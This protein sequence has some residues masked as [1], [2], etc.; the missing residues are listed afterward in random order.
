MFC[1]SDELECILTLVWMLFGFCRSRFAG[2][3]HHA[4][5]FEKFLYLFIFIASV[6]LDDGMHDVVVLDLGIVV[7]FK[8]D[9]VCQFFL[10]RAKLLAG[11]ILY[12]NAVPSKGRA[13]YRC[14]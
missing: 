3:I 13:V 4:I 8:D 2:T 12:G 6:A 1:K 5:G 7:E 11:G 9:A 14:Q 10:V